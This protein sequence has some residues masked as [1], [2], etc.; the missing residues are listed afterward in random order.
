MKSTVIIISI[1]VIVLI[2]GC[3][4]AI[5]AISKRSESDERKIIDPPIAPAPAP[6][7]VEEVQ[8]EWVKPVRSK[9]EASVFVYNNC[10]CESDIIRGSTAAP[11]NSLELLGELSVYGDEQWKCIKSKNMSI[12]NFEVAYSGISNGD[13]VSYNGQLN[14]VDKF[15]NY[16]IGCKP[17]DTKFRTEGLK[18]NFNVRE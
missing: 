4:F 7:P 17:G 16:K 9:K 14:M 11:N 18:F 1:V 15:D 12:S 5:S 3:L 13:P 8:D 10:D 6:A 2:I